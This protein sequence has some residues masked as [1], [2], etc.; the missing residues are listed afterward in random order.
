[1]RVIAGKFKSRQLKSVD[2]KLTRPTTDKNK[3]N[4]F[5]MIGPFFNGGVCLDLFGGSGGLGIEAI[6]RGMDELYSVDKQYKAFA[7]IKEN[8]QTLKIQDVA[9]VYK[10]DYQKALQQ[11]AN[12][13]IQFDLVFLDPPYGLKI[14]QKILDFLVKNCMLKQGCLLVIE[15]LNEEVIEIKEPFVLKKQQSY[16][17]TTLQIIVYEE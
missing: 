6:S 7:T 2:S 5:N 14:S 15:D 12:E 10:M 13:N 9:H 8:I 17:I 16:G 11:F 3:E 1:M 4:L